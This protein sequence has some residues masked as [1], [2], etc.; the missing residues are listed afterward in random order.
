VLTACPP[1]T[2]SRLETFVE[3]NIC[4]YERNLP[5]DATISFRAATTRFK[6]STSQSLTGHPV[7]HL[8]VSRSPA[9]PAS[10]T[11]KMS[12]SIDQTRTAAAAALIDSLGLHVT[13]V[14]RNWLSEMMLSRHPATV[15]SRAAKMEARATVSLGPRTVSLKV[16]DRSRGV[17]VIGSGRKRGGGSRGLW[18]GGIGMRKKKRKTRRRKNQRRLNN[19]SCDVQIMMMG[20]SRDRVKPDIS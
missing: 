20:A 15:G 10:F 11:T 17:R 9:S 12:S 5:L 1:C 19:G 13:D 14:E 18:C 7:Q 16:D 2:R 3:P 8:L 6:V 4:K